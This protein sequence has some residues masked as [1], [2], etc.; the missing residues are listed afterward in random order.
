MSKAKILAGA[1]SAGGVLADG[2]VSAAE[3]SGLAA[4]AT[5]GSYNDLSDKPVIT[6]TASNLAGGAAG[7]VPYQSAAG[8]TAMLAAG[9]AGQVLQTN[10]AGAP[11]WVTPSAGAFT[12]Y[13]QSADQTIT[14]SGTLTL[15]HG[16]GAAP[17]IVQGFVKNITAQGDYVPGDILSMGL[18]IND[19]SER[20]VTVRI[21]ATNIYIYYGGNATVFVTGGPPSGYAYFLINTRWKFFVRAAA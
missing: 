14:T 20:G 18:Y 3:V 13:F 1:V 6:T 4:V 15:A 12:A 21:D 5:S 7:A 17:K 2:A 8:A 19:A 11:T 16:L 10:G 9:T